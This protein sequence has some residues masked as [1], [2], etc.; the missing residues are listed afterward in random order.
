VKVIHAPNLDDSS[1]LPTRNELRI[2]MK[3]AREVAG[4]VAEGQK[5]LTTCWMG[6]NRSGLVNALAI[7][8]LTGMDG[9]SCVDLIQ[10]RRPMTLRNPAFCHVLSNIEEAP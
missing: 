6:H 10:K 8:L 1:R 4:L 2:A 9:A 3:A 7:H 5:V